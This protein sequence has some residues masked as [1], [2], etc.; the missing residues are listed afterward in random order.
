L[1]HQG[2]VNRVFDEMGAHIPLDQ[3][4]RQP[5]RRCSRRATLDLSLSRPRGRLSQ[6]RLL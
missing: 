2:R 3:C 5:A 4:L 1:K 6:A